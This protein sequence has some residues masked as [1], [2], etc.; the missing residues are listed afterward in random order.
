[1]TLEQDPDKR[2]DKIVSEL[3]ERISERAQEVAGH[4][5]ADQGTT[6]AQL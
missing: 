5:P 1:M 2:I 4:I 3:C 6:T